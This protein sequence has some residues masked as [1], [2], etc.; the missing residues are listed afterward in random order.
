MHV[1]TAGVMK[2]TGAWAAEFGWGG[3]EGGSSLV[4]RK[5]EGKLKGFCWWMVCLCV[6]SAGQPHWHDHAL[7]LKQQQSCHS[8]QVQQTGD[9]Q[10]EQDFG[11]TAAS[12][13]HR[14]SV[15]HQSCAAVCTGGELLNDP[16][17]CILLCYI[18][19]HCPMLLLGSLQ[20]TL[21]GCS[22]Q[23]KHCQ[24]CTRVKQSGVGGLHYQ[25]HVHLHSSA[26]AASPHWH[27]P[28]LQPGARVCTPHCW[29]P[30]T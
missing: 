21:L 9:L 26:R 28:Q 7:Q 29:S 2:V 1:L 17:R 25:W 6:W 27:D 18:N 8:A 23:H 5:G 3:C 24:E 19:S 11:R 22:K 30:V 16:H 15:L 4:R 14:A 13:S 12:T 20:K 10:H